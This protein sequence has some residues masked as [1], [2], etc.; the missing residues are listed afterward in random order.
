MS[1][2]KFIFALISFCVLQELRNKLLA[3]D[4]RG[5]DALADIIATTAMGQLDLISRPASALPQP[6]PPRAS[7]KT[8]VPLFQQVDVLPVAPPQS[9]SSPQTNQKSQMAPAASGP[10]LLV[11]LGATDPST[12][13]GFLIPSKL[14]G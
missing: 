3:I 13:F 6:S 4:L 1:K 7:P 9:S 5:P 14:S 8:V 2:V 12:D 10:D 11:L